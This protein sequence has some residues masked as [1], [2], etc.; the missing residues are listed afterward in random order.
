MVQ[1]NVFTKQTD[2]DRK[3]TSDYQNGK[4]LKEG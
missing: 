3:Q 2:S 4:R 1:M